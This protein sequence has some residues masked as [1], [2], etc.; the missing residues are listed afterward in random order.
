MSTRSRVGTVLRTWR[1]KAAAWAFVCTIGV[2]LWIISLSKPGGEEV[3]LFDLK[4]Y[5]GAIAGA[6]AGGSLYD[7]VFHHHTIRPEGLGFTYPPFAALPLWPLTWLSSDAAGGLWT[8]A[9]LVTVV[10]VALVS[11]S[12]RRA[13]GLRGAWLTEGAVLTLVMLLSYPVISNVLL[14]QI[15]LFL[16]AAT[17]LDAVV[18]PPRWRGVLTGLAGAIKL[19]PLVFIPYFAATRQ[20]RAAIT[21]TATFAAATLVGFLVF[22][23]DSVAYWTVRLWDTDKVGDLDAVR[24][25]SL[26]GLLDRWLPTFGGL[27]ILWVVLTVALVA[28]ALRAA[29]RHARLGQ[30]VE[31]ATVAGTLGI[32]ALPVSWPHYLTWGLVAGWILLTA[33]A[34][35]WR[36]LGLATVVGLSLPSPLLDANPP[37]PAAQQLGMELPVLLFV[38]I[39][40]LGLP[41]GE[42]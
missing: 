26:Y 12:A 39:S 28:L 17:L 20:W 14:G 23:G 1:A 40:A 37:L 25:K 32:A 29:A 38:G 42:P 27:K 22:P 24:N 2:Q 19:T 4:I 6:A 9:I 16:M 8:A 41:R 13:P 15:S 3:Y 10:V 34:W 5:R 21:A 31:A 30:P 35:R 7:Y 18:V 33:D 11:H 36:L